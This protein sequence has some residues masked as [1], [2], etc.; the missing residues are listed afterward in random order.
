MLKT[1]L[2]VLLRE[3]FIDLLIVVFY[4]E[5]NCRLK[6]FVR[7][8]DMKYG[9][10]ILD[11]NLKDGFLHL[12]K[13]AFVGNSLIKKH[14]EYNYLYD[15]PWLKN[16]DMFLESVV[17]AYMVDQIL[18]KEPELHQEYKKI[19]EQHIK[20][21][22]NGEKEVNKKADKSYLWF[23]HKFLCW[24][25][26]YLREQANPGILEQEREQREREQ[27]EIKRNAEIRK[28]QAARKEQQ[29]LASGKRVI[30]PYCKSTNTEKISTLN[31][32]VSIS[33]VGVAS[34]K[35]GKQWHC[36]N[37]NSNF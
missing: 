8:N 4:N 21:W 29:D 9:D 5:I 36:K 35:L 15:D 37:C 13:R 31:R 10:M 20:G 27:A 25:Q 19:I 17:Y 23:N 12:S 7:F 34:S 2:V 11:V 33:I 30:C 3:A 1:E 6:S 28:Y 14:P 24:Y 18:K 32:A 22:A 16:Q 26:D